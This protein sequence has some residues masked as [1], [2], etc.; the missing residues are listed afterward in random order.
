MSQPLLSMIPNPDQWRLDPELAGPGA[1]VTDIGLYPL[2]TARFLLED[3]PVAV[4]ASMDSSSEAFADVPDERAAFTLEFPAGVFAT[5]TASQAAAQSSHVEVIGTEGRA[6]IDPAFFPDDPRQVTVSRGGTTVDVDFEQV[7]QMREEFDYFAD[8]VLTGREPEG[9]G[10]HGLTDM[11]II[12]AIY[13]A[14]GRGERVE[15]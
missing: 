15:L 11:R 6:R 2:N 9:D 14:G 3:D 4:Q 12:E 5:C 7:D 8:C 13:A 1:S 10:E